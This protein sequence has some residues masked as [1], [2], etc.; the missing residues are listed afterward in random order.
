MRSVPIGNFAPVYFVSFLEEY[1]TP[2]AL[3]ELIQARRMALET[4]GVF[5]DCT[6]T[7][8]WDFYFGDKEALYA[9]RFAQARAQN[10][11][12]EPQDVPRLR[13]KR[14]AAMTASDAWIGL[15]PRK[16]QRRL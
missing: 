9:E 10:P 6:P 13:P 8:A 12:V 14:A 1:S 16:R 3:P 7:M 5:A 15:S 2:N 11:L 4:R